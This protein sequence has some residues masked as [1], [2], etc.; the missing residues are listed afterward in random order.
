MTLI[1]SQ[2]TGSSYVLSLLLRPPMCVPKPVLSLSSLSK[3]QSN[4][5]RGWE[6]AGTGP[7]R[8]CHSPQCLFP[9]TKIDL[10]TV[11]ATLS[12][13]SAR[14]QSSA[15]LA[16]GGSDSGAG[17][18]L[19]PRRAVSPSLCQRGSSRD[20]SVEEGQIQL[21]KSLRCGPCGTSAA[22]ATPS[23]SGDEASYSPYHR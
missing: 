9:A 19:S 1:F 7:A 15:G 23:S 4:N 6:G 2:C 10:E 21:Q 17:G 18:S 12:V 20:G 22:Q 11:S 8:A 3:P 14:C 16:D 5:H 13:P